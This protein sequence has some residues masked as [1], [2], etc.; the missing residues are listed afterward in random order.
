MRGE[1]TAPPQTRLRDLLWKGSDSTQFRGFVVT[2]DSTTA[3]ES[4][5]RQY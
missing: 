3:L 1:H 2:L 5:C 4:S